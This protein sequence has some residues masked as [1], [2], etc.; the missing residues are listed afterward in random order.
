MKHMN[1]ALYLFHETQ[2]LF[3]EEFRPRTCSIKSHCKNKKHSTISVQK[4]KTK[5]YL[6]AMAKKQH[7]RSAMAKKTKHYLSAMAILKHNYNSVTGSVIQIYRSGSGRQKWRG[8]FGCKHRSVASTC[9]ETQNDCK[10]RHKETRLHQLATEATADRS[11]SL[12]RPDWSLLSV[13]RHYLS[14]AANS[15][16]NSKIRYEGEDAKALILEMKLQMI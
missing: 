13:S 7:Y 4:Q 3:H 15:D 16:Q 2:R 5:H 11:S 6:S 8:S 9:N 10:I 14:A 12:R 1:F